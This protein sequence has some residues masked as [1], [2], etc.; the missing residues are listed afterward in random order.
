MHVKE[1]IAV[2]GNIGGNVVVAN[3]AIGAEVE[4][5]VHSLDRSPDHICSVDTILGVNK[6]SQSAK[7]RFYAK[8]DFARNAA[9]DVAKNMQHKAVWDN[10]SEQLRNAD[11]F[12]AE[13][14]ARDLLGEPNKK[15]S[16]GR[17]LR[18]GEHGK[19]A[20]RISGERMGTWY[21]FSNST[22]EDIFA[23]VQEKQ[24]CDF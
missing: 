17:T 18:F 9:R 16:D 24:A 19:I 15:L 13:Q 12:K 20:V 23:L 14:I 1:K 8:A 11:R 2:G 4:G 21:D 5:N 22:G 6:S 10:E 3:N 7:Q